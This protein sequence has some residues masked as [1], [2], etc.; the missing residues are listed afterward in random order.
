MEE[1]LREEKN[2]RR[3]EWI[4]LVTYGDY[5][6]RMGVQ[7]VSQAAAKTMA[8]NFHS[9][10]QRLAR[11]FRGIPIYVGHP[12]DG[13]FLGRAGHGDTRAYGWVRQMEARADG[14]WIRVRW[15]KEGLHMLD[16]AHYKFLSP[17]W[18]MEMIGGGKLR[19]RALIS[20]GLTN[21]PNMAVEAVANVDTA[22][23]PT[24][25]LGS[26]RE[27]MRKEA[28]REAAQKAEPTPVAANCHRIHALVSGCS[29]RSANL[30]QRRSGGRGA[31]KKS[32]ERLLTIVNERMRSANESYGAA[33]RAVKGTRPEL[34]DPT[35]F[36]SEEK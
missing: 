10:W 29:A 17:R 7:E 8:D 24:T 21:C 18:E 36:P 13:E 3:W 6:H 1:H 33:W 26:V 22:P 34:F 2:G 15:S 11:R 23:P 19:P 27:A 14:L 25:V 20:I 31:A 4:K 12:D 16:C 35:P 28:E 32:T 5:A 30:L 9:L